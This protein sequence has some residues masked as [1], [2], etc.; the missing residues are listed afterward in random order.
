[1]QNTSILDTKWI[2]VRPKVTQIFGINKATYS[3]FGL[4]GHNGLDLR[5]KVGTPLFAPC[6]GQVKI[7][8]DGAHAGYGKWI[9]IRSGDREITLGHLNSQ[10]ITDGAYVKMGQLIGYTGN[11]GFSTGPHLHITLKQLAPSS[12]NIWLWLV[13]NQGNGFKGAYDPQPYLLTWKGTLLN[14]TVI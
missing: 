8:F 13:K 2:Q 1:L 6:D 14:D 3:Q 10:E 11:T 9:K 5:C 12:Q 4:Q 7:G